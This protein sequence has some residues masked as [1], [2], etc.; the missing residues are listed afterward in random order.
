MEFYVQKDGEESGPFDEAKLRAMLADGEV[1]ADDSA[2]TDPS[3]DW[4]TVESVLAES[5]IDADQPAPSKN[6]GTA[7]AVL[8][9]GAV[10]VWFF[11]FWD[12]PPP[13]RSSDEI[14]A[15]RESLPA[16][17]LA[18]KL[19]KRITAPGDKRYFLNAES[20]EIYWRAMTCKNPKCPAV[21]DGGK[22]SIFIN[23]NP[24]VVLHPDGTLGHYPERAAKAA[25][26]GPIVACPECLK[27]RDVA[28]ESIETKEIYLSYVR[29]YILPETAKRL[30]EL[31]NEQK[32]R[33][34]SGSSTR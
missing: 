3:S 13:P 17:F 15:E 28:T 2:R 4:A 14:F 19:E 9:F 11:G 30:K 32:S 6:M 1:A 29:P 22:P 16:L 18:G 20:K 25:E 21:K 33:S 24:A 34:G 23:P 7:V 10:A 5:E 31:D 27:T 26:A 12:T 8:A